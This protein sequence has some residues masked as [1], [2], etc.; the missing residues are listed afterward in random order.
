[1]SQ[2]QPFTRDLPNWKPGLRSQVKVGGRFLLLDLAGQGSAAV[3]YKARDSW[4]DKLVALKVLKGSAAA[5]PRLAA[6]FRRECE[7]GRQIQHP[8]VVSFV[9]SGLHEGWTYLAMDYIGGRTLAELLS[10]TPRMPMI[11]VEALCRQML[12]ALTCIHDAGIVH[13]DLKPSNLM[14]GTGGNW[15]LMDFGISRPQAGD[16]TVGPPVGTPQ[17]MSPEQ[18]LGDA[19]SVQSDL[20]SAGVVL[21]EALT[22]RLPFAQ[23]GVRE[24][25][26]TVPPRA[27]GLR[28]GVPVWLDAMVARCLAVSPKDR[29]L[30]AA[31]MASHLGPF[32][33]IAVPASV[34]PTVV[35]PPLPVAPPAP[36][37]P[38]L[39][40]YLTDAPGKP[41]D[42]LGMM[43]DVLRVLQQ[44][45][46]RGETSD[47][48][49][50]DSVH[51]LPSGRVEIRGGQRGSG[52][53]DTM[54]VANPKYAAPE[55][56]HGEAPPAGAM[57]TQVNLYSVGFMTYEFLLGRDQFRR[58]FPGME[59]TGSG[60]AWMEWHSDSSK[61]IRPVAEVLL[62]SPLAVSELV[63]GMM[64]KDPARRCATYEEAIAKIQ[65]V[66][67]RTK[68]T[69]EINAPPVSQGKKSG[70]PWL[71]AV[72]AGVVLL[73]LALLAAGWLIRER[74][75][76]PW[77]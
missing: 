67:N 62:R 49:S 57:W 52:T 27:A 36:E 44:R 64:E 53:R 24:R 75:G 26:T 31:E 71:V 42:V 37:P 51:R 56:L 41:E 48:I 35:P 72:I 1:M 33:E 61:R 59:D 25:C 60:L 3:V 39:R 50:P 23:A 58:Q 70:R 12:A 74:G 77:L 13:R 66:I 38:V 65:A 29:F 46:V 14:L 21:Y 19:T 45:A 20:Y 73:M 47:P 11:E 16:A 43:L 2:A 28:P 34:A 7:I 4:T 15:K 76:L 32:E 9:A 69:Q 54:L 6:G 18:M 68:A 55:L 5:H 10:L 17:Y 22:G 40:D 63:A 8:N 30:S